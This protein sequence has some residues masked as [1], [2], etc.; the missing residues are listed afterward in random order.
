MQLDHEIE[1]ARIKSQTA[2]SI[3]TVVQIQNDGFLCNNGVNHDGNPSIDN[4]ATILNNNSIR[5]HIQG[6]TE[7]KIEK[8]AV[9]NKNDTNSSSDGEILQK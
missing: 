4:I 6:K 1:L 9:D 2:N 7:R 8:E 3:P 5:T